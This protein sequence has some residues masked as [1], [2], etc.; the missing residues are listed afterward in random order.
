M[1]YIIEA[2]NLLINYFVSKKKNEVTSVILSGLK[3]LIESTLNNVYV[4]ITAN[5]IRAVAVNNK[6]T[7]KMETT[8][9]KLVRPIP[10]SIDQVKETYNWRLPDTITEKYM[11]LISEYAT[12]KE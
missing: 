7:F 4:D 2:E 1:C 5:S 11:E 10:L 3:N 8:K 6:K 9:V 12:H